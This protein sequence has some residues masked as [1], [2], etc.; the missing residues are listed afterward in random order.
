[1][2][3]A[4]HRPGVFQNFKEHTH[5]LDLN[6]A[7]LN[8]C[9]RIDLSDLRFFT[10]AVMIQRETGAIWQRFWTKSPPSSGALQVAQSSGRPNRGRPPFGIVLILLPPVTTL[11]LLFVNPDYIM[12]LWITPKGG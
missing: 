5:G 11:A 10:T 6:A 7:L 12:Q 8:L 3:W 2:R 1:M 9:K 4:R